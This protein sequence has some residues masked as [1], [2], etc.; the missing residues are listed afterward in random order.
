M[1]DFFMRRKR[2]NGEFEEEASMR[3]SMLHEEENSVR[4]QKYVEVVIN[5]KYPD[6]KAKIGKGLTKEVTTQL[7]EFLIKHMDNCA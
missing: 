1:I 5:L 4:K 6:Q 3:V 2:Q 7:K